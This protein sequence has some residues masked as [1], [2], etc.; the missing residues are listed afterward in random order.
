MIAYLN[1]FGMFTLISA[2][3]IPITL[4]VRPGK[5]TQASGG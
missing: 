3:A 2:I 4:L 1:T 5:P